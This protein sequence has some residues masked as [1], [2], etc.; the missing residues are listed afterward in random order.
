MQQYGIEKFIY[1]S[2]DNRQIWL[3]LGQSWIITLQGAVYNLSGVASQSLWVYVSPRE[4]R[5][6]NELLNHTIDQFFF[7]DT[8]QDW[9]Q[10]NGL[11]GS[12]YV[13]IKAAP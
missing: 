13:H 4:Q 12:C 9:G 8:H 7:S 5:A 11:I 6:I 2:L 1:F 10:L 3:K